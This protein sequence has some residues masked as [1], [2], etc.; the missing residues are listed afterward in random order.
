MQFIENLEMPIYNLSNIKKPAD[1]EVLTD[2]T[3]IP[4]EGL[5][6]N[7]TKDSIYRL[8]VQQKKNSNLIGLIILELETVNKEQEMLFNISTL[9]QN[10]IL[11]P[12]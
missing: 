5:K 1:C 9:F 7:E 8:Q 2:S 6:T 11:H 12:M 3:R 10:N 4:E